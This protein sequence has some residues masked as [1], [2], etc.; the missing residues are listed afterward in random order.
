MEC[1]HACEGA[2]A[3]VSHSVCRLVSL[4][5]CLSVSLWITLTTLPLQGLCSS[6]PPVVPHILPIL[7]P[8]PYQLVT[9]SVSHTL[10]PPFLPD[11]SPQIPP[12]FTVLLPSPIQQ[13]I[14]QDAEKPRQCYLPFGYLEKKNFI[15]KAPC[16]IKMAELHKYYRH[17]AKIL[18]K[19]AHNGNEGD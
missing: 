12:L 2:G 10:C 6:N 7:N 5:L 11:I 3:V 8:V 9:G 14:K 16:L 4:S 17:F 13:L 15:R 1:V 18:N 19:R